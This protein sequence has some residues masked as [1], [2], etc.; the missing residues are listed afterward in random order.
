MNSGLP[1]SGIQRI[2]IGVSPANSEYVYLLASRSSNGG[3]LAYYRST[4]GGDDFT[5]MSSTPNILGY[6]ISG[7]DMGGQGSYDLV[8]AV[9]PFDI[10]TV[11]T[12][13]INL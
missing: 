12:G 10:N 1:A 3:F 8:T 4:N 7:S 2:A 13:G 5:T 9:S 11:Y 6:E